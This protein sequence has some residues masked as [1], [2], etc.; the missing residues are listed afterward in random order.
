[1][2][3]IKIVHLTVYELLYGVQNIGVFCVNSM[4]AKYPGIQL[5]KQVHQFFFYDSE[6]TSGS[7]CSVLFI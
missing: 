2:K 6:H 4:V 1:M 3:K 5:M 7:D